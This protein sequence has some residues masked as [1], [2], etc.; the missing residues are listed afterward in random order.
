[1]VS[2]SV[3]VWRTPPP[4]SV[5]DTTLVTGAITDAGGAFRVEGLRPGRFRIVVSF[6][7]YETERVEDVVLRP[8][9]T[10]EADVGTVA[11]APD[12]EALD[13]VEVEA[14]REQVSVQ[15]DRT[16]YNTADDPVAAGGTATNVLETIPSVDVDVDGNVSLRGSGNVA[17]LI[18]GKPA[19]V[20]SEF[21][22]AYLQSLPAGSIERVEVIPNPS[23]RY[24]PDGMG[25]I[26]NIVLKEEVDRGLGGTAS[27]GADSRGGYSGT[28]L[29]TY[30]GGPWNLSG[31]YG[32]RQENDGGGGSSFAQNLADTPVTFLDQVEDEEEDETSHNF[33]LSA[34]YA[35]GDRTA[36]SSSV[37][38]GVRDEAE[39]EVNDFLRLDDERDPTLAYE[40]L[41]EEVSDRRTFDARLGFRHDFGRGAGAPDGRPADEAA[42]TLEVEV[43]YDR[44]V[45]DD[46][47]TYDQRLLSA[48]A[49]AGDDIREYQLSTRERDRDEASLEVDYVRPLGDFRLEAG[50]KG[51]LETQYQS[52]FVETRDEA[53]GA[54][55][56]DADLNN[57]FD[58]EQQ[59][60][61]AYLQLAREFGPLGL[62]AGLRAE[63]AQTT[64]ALL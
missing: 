57:T 61:A 23:A 9:G 33:N 53:T 14:E 24:E 26:I 40:R 51:D 6:V 20:S 12:V 52:L 63:T 3:A 38:F 58:Y 44:S 42:H 62:Q 16:V 43:R 54:F 59:V 1:L 27:A 2:A 32:L 46:D 49:D 5:R 7:G 56:P 30:G 35:L 34:D 31:S 45:N 13:G 60:H 39:L 22:A 50:Y 21:I 4:E 19:P 36:L 17:V 28:A 47:E 18:N 11:L 37:Q 15:I 25:G 10:M 29:L 55:E 8:R 41:V 64:F 48:A